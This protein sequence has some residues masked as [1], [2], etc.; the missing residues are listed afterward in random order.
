MGRHKSYDREKVLDKALKLFWEK[1]YEGAHLQELVQVTGLNRFSLYKEF[2][3]KEG[4]FDEALEKY[5]CDLMTLGENLMREPKGLANIRQYYREVVKYPW[6]QGC[7]AVNALT[8]HPAIPEKNQKRVFQL[9]KELEKLMYENLQAAQKNG[10]IGKGT[11]IQA[12]A[13]LLMAIDIG[14]IV[15]HILNSKRDIKNN[16]VAIINDLLLAGTGSDARI[17]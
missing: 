11:N 2:G 1:G 16:M 14:V 12:F 4:L 9:F 10:E 6:H 15:S 13:S 8:H 5:C 17:E 3:S 7:F